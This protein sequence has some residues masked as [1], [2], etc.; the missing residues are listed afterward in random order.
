MHILGDIDNPVGED[1]AAFVQ[2]TVIRRISVKK[3]QKIQ[4]KCKGKNVYLQKV[5][6]KRE[7]I[8][9]K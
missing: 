7:K 6:S 5:N 2:D 9:E 3:L 8:L 1:G 4:R